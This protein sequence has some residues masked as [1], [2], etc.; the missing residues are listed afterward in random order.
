MTQL[1]TITSKRQLTIPVDFY[2]RLGLVQGQKVLIKEISGGLRL[3]P[4]EAL[5]D[6]LAGSVKIPARFKG[7]SADEM[8]TFSKKEYF[9]RKKQ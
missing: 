8:I 4:A 6:Q 5:V 7:L 3:E 1:A 2:N 9:N